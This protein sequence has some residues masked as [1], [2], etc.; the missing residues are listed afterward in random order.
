MY[1][2]LIESVVEFARTRYGD[3]IWEKARKKA[4]IETNA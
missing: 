2:L 3:A 4:K 1:G